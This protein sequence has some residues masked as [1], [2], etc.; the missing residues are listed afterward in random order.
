MLGIT[1]RGTSIVTPTFL[2]YVQVQVRVIALWSDYS[3]S[4]RVTRHGM[5]A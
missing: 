2:F 3:G 4:F 5:V 1:K